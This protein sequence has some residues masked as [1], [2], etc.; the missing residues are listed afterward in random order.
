M[1]GRDLGC[2]WLWTWAGGA[3]A[4]DPADGFARELGPRVALDA[5]LVTAARV[6]R[7]SGLLGLLAHQARQE[8]TGALILVHG[9]ADDVT[10]TLAAAWRQADL[11]AVELEVDV[12]LPGVELALPGAMLRG[13][14][15]R[16]ARLVTPAGVAALRGTS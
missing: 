2:G 1:T 8:R 6:D 3:L 16:V 13:D 7:V 5:V 11:A 15:P 12:L 9:L 4:V 14:L 10:P